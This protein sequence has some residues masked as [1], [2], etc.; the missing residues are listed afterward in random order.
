MTKFE[1]LNSNMDM[2]DGSRIAFK[3]F[4]VFVFGGGQQRYLL[5]LDRVKKG[6]C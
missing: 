1:V 5:R 6:I 2:K 3:R 4:K